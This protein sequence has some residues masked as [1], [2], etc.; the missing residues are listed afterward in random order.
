MANRHLSRVIIMQTLFEWDFRPSLD[1]FE[2]VKRNIKAYDEECDTGY[3]EVTLKGIIDH[4]KE[5]DQIISK[6]APEWPIDQIAIIDKSILRVAVYEL[7]YPKEIP[8]KVVINEAV[9]LGKTYGSESTYKFVNGVLGTLFKDD[10]R[11]AKE[12]ENS[13]LLDLHKKTEKHKKREKNDKKS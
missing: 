6:A 7:L 11:Y 12:L 10:E 8:P 9:E 13:T 5:I 2:I 1:V 4:H 3:I